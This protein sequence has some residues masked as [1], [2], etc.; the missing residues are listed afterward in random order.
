MTKTAMG[1]FKKTGFSHRG[2]LEE[3]IS[4]KTFIFTLGKM[5]GAGGYEYNCFI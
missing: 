3:D 2:R 1:T 5:E 4:F